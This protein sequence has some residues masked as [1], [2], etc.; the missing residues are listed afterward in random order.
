MTTKRRLMTNSASGLAERLVNL[1]VQLWLYQYLIK[2]IS[3]EEYSLYPVVMA[4][5]VFAPPLMA[6]LITGL[7]R[8]IVEAD[9]CNNHQRVT[10]ITSTMFPVLSAAA[11]GLVLLTLVAAKYLSSILNIAPHNLSE[12]RLMVLLL[13]GN[14]A[15]RAGLSPFG[16]GLYVC[17]K[18]V[19]INTLNI[20]NTVIRVALLFILLLGAGPR[21]LWVV[22]ATVASDVAIVLVGTILSVRALPA[23]KFRFECIHWKMLPSLMTFGF[24]NMIGSIGLLIRT[25]SDLLILNR[26]ATPIDV[27]TFHLASL[28]DNQINA[29]L[30]KMKEP[31]QPHIVAVHSTGGLAALQTP[32]IRGSRYT[33]W[34]ALLVATPLMA[35]RQQLWSHYLGS[36]LEVYADAPLVMML[37]LMRYWVEGPICMLGM[38]AQAMKRVRTLSILIIAQSLSN[39]AITVYFVRALHMGAVGSALGTL[40]S[41]VTWDVFVM[42]KVTLNFLGLKFGPWFKATV[43]R[44][45]LPSAVAGLFALG[46][47][48]WMQPETIP[49]LLLATAIVASVYL[50][51]LLLFCLDE[52]E[53]RQLKQLFAKFSSQKTYKA[54]ASWNEF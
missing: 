25:S 19:V 49:E 42:W 5:L 14:L 8:D 21:V 48:H 12:G 9:A 32:C 18:F 38:A 3:P 17:Q 53:H 39:V 20:V 37:L 35:F 33:M 47:R 22:V 43:W 36:K 50:F 24:W 1:L 45:V 52:D 34:A 29:A 15:L 44:A 2:R 54:L 26:F 16:V 28:P 23:L 13:F 27:N 10:E 11:L 41:L 6:L 4:L 40:I 7:S 51:S 31:L 46:W 30:D